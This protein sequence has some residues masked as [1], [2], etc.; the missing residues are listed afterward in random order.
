MFP[1]QESFVDPIWT[2]VNYRGKILSDGSLPVNLTF[3]KEANNRTFLECFRMLVE[4]SGNFLLIESPAYYLSYWP[5]LKAL[6]NLEPDELPF[7]EELV[8]GA[9]SNRLM[10][11][12]HLKRES[13]SAR[14][15]LD[16][17]IY[18]DL[19]DDLDDGL[20]IDIVTIKESEVFGS[21]QI[22]LIPREKPQAIISENI[23][24]GVV[25]DAS[26]NEA[27]KLILENRV[28][29]VQGPP[30]T[31]KTFLGVQAVKV[32]L[33]MKNT[34]GNPLI[35][36]PI[37]VLTYKNHALD[38]FSKHIIKDVFSSN[39]DR[40][41]FIR[42]GGQS[43]DGEMRKYSIH[44]AL[45]RASFVEHQHK[46]DLEIISEE[47]LNE[48][49]DFK[50]SC[51]VLDI[52]VLKK[53][54]T[55]AQIANLIKVF[56]DHNPTFVQ[57]FQYL[58]WHFGEIQ[59]MAVR[60]SQL[61]DNREHQ[62]D[63]D[64]LELLFTQ[65]LITWLPDN[66]F[67]SKFIELERKKQIKQQQMLFNN[68]SELVTEEKLGDVDMNDLI[69][70]Y[71]EKLAED[72]L[73]VSIHGKN[74]TST[75]NFRE[76]GTD[77]SK[78]D[79]ENLCLCHN[80]LLTKLL[81]T[82]VNIEDFKYNSNL[83]DMSLLERFQFLQAMLFK[84]CEVAS[85]KLKTSFDHFEG[86]AVQVRK[87]VLSREVLV[88]QEAKLFAM[89][90]SGAAIRN[91]ALNMVKPSVI[92]VE[93]A[94]EISESHLIALLGSHVKHLILIGDHKQL[95]PQVECHDLVKRYDFN[96]SMMERLIN[97]SL[98]YA[99]LSTQN[100]M[101]PDISKYLLDIYPE[102]KDNTRVYLNKEVAGIQKNCFFW[103]HDFKEE[104][105]RSPVNREEAKVVI[106]LAK[107]LCQFNGY[108][109]GQITI[110]S[111]YKGQTALLRKMA[112]NVHTQEERLDIQTI[113]MFQGDE[114]DIVIVSTTRN[115]PE[116]NPGFMGILNRRCVAQ[117][118][119]KSGVYFLGNSETLKGAT[120]QRIKPS[121]WSLFFQA[122]EADDALG[123][124]LVLQCQ[125]HK[126]VTIN[127]KVGD[128]FPSEKN[129]FCPEKCTFKMSCGVHQCKRNCQPYH[130]R[131]HYLCEELV[132]FDYKCGKHSSIEKCHIDKD[133]LVC[134]NKCEYKFHTESYSQVGVHACSLKCEPA[135]SHDRCKTEV[136]FSCEKNGHRMIRK[137][138]QDPNSLHCEAN[139]T[140]LF[141]FCG[142]HQGIAKCYEDE[143]Q[144]KCPKVCL[145]Y[146]EPC[147]HPC[148][149]N[150][151]PKHGHDS[152]SDACD[153]R[154]KYCCNQ[155]GGTK[156]RMCYQ[157]E[158][159]V[160]CQ[161]NV[162]FV[163]PKCGRHNGYRKCCQKIEDMVC[164][165]RC[166]SQLPDCP[167]LCKKP[168]K[169]E[170]SHS[171]DVHKCE[172][173]VPFRHKCDKVLNRLCWQSED[174][175]LCDGPCTQLL[176][177]LH[178]CPLRCDPPHEHEANS[179]IIC[180]EEVEVNCENCGSSLSKLCFED[181][182]SSKCSADVKFKHS[183]GFVLSRPCN[184]SEAEIVCTGQCRK[185][186]KCGHRCI[187]KC[188]YDHGH[189]Y[190]CLKNDT[191]S[192]KSCS[193]RL[194]KRCCDD[195]KDIKCSG[196]MTHLCSRCNAESRGPCD[197]SDCKFECR[198]TCSQILI[199]GHKCSLMC[200]ELCSDSNCR[201][202]LEDQRSKEKLERDKREVEK[203]RE[204]EAKKLE[205]EKELQRFSSK[206]PRTVKEYRINPEGDDSA[207]FFEVTDMVMKYLKVTK[208]YMP[209]INSVYMVSNQ[210]GQKSLAEAQLKLH[211]RTNKK[212]MCYFTTEGR[213]KVEE[214]VNNGFHR[215]FY[216][217]TQ[218]HYG[219]YSES[220]NHLEFTTRS[221]EV[222][223]KSEDF[224][225]TVLVCD[226]LVGR[227]KTVKSSSNIPKTRKEMDPRFDSILYRGTFDDE[228]P[229]HIIYDPSHVVITERVEFTVEPIKSLSS[230][231]SL[232]DGM[233]QKIELEPRR[234]FLIADEKQHYCRMALSQYFA[235]CR[236]S[237]SSI[238]KIKSIH[239][240]FNPNLE[241]KFDEKQTEIKEKYKESKHHEEILAFHGTGLSDPEIIMKEN[242]S[243]KKIK[244]TAY[245]YGI[246]FS[247]YVSTSNSYTENTGQ[248]ILARVLLGKSV[249]SDKC[250]RMNVRGAI[251]NEHDS[252]TVQPSEKGHARMVIIQNVDQILPMFIIR[253]E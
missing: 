38:E 17:D 114:N 11:F 193:K 198:S 159:D 244:R 150:C 191:F 133:E 92:I 60:L 142:K 108:C 136:V 164:L 174:T 189:D 128:S 157:N 252:H 253:T 127:V 251:C 215:R 63:I 54:L 22:D 229:R 231:E 89:T 24:G 102:L 247:E 97:N 155:C 27:M 224:H 31:G 113:D 182:D 233:F 180:Q 236:D 65:A 34:Y 85:S 165:N 37:L 202:C 14:D 176:K 185:T 175:I 147:G 48:F 241:T 81:A 140:F 43:K 211:D 169:E 104:S 13:K 78:S 3:S 118:R 51:S 23:L 250:A 116:K 235:G 40:N 187:K 68:L 44:S 83:F 243:L 135:H 213:R 168:C 141:S 186:L 30:G 73:N 95:P 196:T 234:N 19:G 166:D 230:D 105:G 120:S 160:L 90:I 72:R 132:D 179:T 156:R 226:V 26:Q 137:C 173:N 18:D 55:P 153:F 190:L 45:H 70:D 197:R 117:S 111:G 130:R 6:Q 49:E 151:E 109:W 206:L 214:L 21:T 170:H 57:E 223:F 87:S 28:A 125:H 101:R 5:V 143:T 152:I 239:L 79:E 210:R 88:L 52:D 42:V 100:R 4:N 7:Q 112:K 249:E 161:N 145:K 75:I 131:E 212:S 184:K 25:L 134:P 99:T 46:Q 167:H 246:Y 12:H 146:M 10:Y 39:A 76:F 1:A 195:E 217:G 103:N 115:N 9:V 20:D 82:R 15:D 126:E 80:G 69:D 232:K 237:D 98:P 227:A 199:C 71:G 162:H 122:L 61:L 29:V 86:L 218:N 8:K 59:N 36:G 242:F 219:R 154:I 123:E 192:C 2:T 222:R 221:P 96:I 58:T 209:K 91:E 138:W 50:S 33:N 204:N 201:K 172:E 62:Q 53:H 149:R 93:E 110:L 183:C 188:G 124:E 248:L 77:N 67:V 208:G 41:D 35:E 106:D 216:P 121:V 144:K 107:Y 200:F 194:N 181:L 178:K 177:C 205:I 47:L 163:Y 64:R 220:I 74:E 238:E 203:Q 119:G 207:K 240:F 84:Q 66:E 171:A 245:G 158:S 129:P 139:I 94:A 228:V 56:L 16:D 225:F 148:T 32:L